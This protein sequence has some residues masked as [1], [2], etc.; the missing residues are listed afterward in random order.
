MT[1]PITIVDDF[2]YATIIGT[3]VGVFIGIIIGICVGHYY[4]PG[5][6]TNKISPD[7]ESRN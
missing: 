4:Q 6:K 1:Y 2:N 7:V 5:H 3:V